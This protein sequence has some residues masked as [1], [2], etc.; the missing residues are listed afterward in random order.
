MNVPPTAFGTP[1]QF[2]G[3]FTSSGGV[4]QAKGS[5][6]SLVMVANAIPK[7]DYCDIYG[8][9]F[10]DVSEIHKKVHSNFLNEQNNG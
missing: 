1:W 10:T 8:S 2:G 3:T 6:V 5:D 4:L 9:I 7:G